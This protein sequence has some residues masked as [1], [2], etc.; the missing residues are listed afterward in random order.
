MACLIVLSTHD[1]YHISSSNIPINIGPPPSRPPLFDSR[2]DLLSRFQLLSAYDRHVRP[3]IHSI[4]GGGRPSSPPSSPVES[5]PGPLASH[6]PLDKG[7][8]K[9]VNTEYDLP[10]STPTP[11]VV[12]ATDGGDGDDNENTEKGEKKAKNSYRHLIKGIPGEYGDI[13]GSL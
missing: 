10:A 7:K 3:H 6:P 12:G 8:G 5:G 13:L 11:G 9:E 2:Q 1:S 4:A